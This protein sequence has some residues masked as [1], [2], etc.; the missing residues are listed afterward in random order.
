[1]GCD[2]CADEDPAEF[3]HLLGATDINGAVGNGGATAGFSAQG[4][5]TVLRWPSPSYFQHV[6]FVTSNDVNARA[7]PHFGA[8]D[9]Q[10][11]FAGVAVDG[12]FA[13]ARDAGWTSTQRY[14]ADDSST[15]VTVQ[16][17]N[18][19]RVSVRYTDT[20]APGLDVLS[21]RIEVTPDPGFVPRALRLVYF[22][23]FSPTVEKADFFPTDQ[24]ARLG[25]RDYAL[26]WSARRAALVHFSLPG[27]PPDLVAPLSGSRTA[28][29]IDATLDGI[30]A[31]GMFILLGA[32]RMPDGFQC[33]WDAGA[34]SA[35]AP[36]DAY[37]DAAA[38]IGALSGAPAALTHADGALRW[39]LPPTGGAVELF[40]AIG[41]TLAQASAALDEARARG[42]DAL[43]AAER[44]ASSALIAGARLP[45]TDDADRLRLAKRA[46][47]SIAV[48]RDRASGAIVASISSQPPY[49]LDWPRDGSFIDYALDVAGLHDWVTQHRAFYTTVQRK[50]DGDDA[51]S[52]SDAFAGSFAMDFYADGRP[53]GPISLEID[54]VGLTLWGWYEHA[55]WL[56][57][58]ARRAY[59]DRVWPSL[60]LAADLLV[61][62]VDQ[63]TRL[64]CAENE[65][66]SFDATI[67]LHG[68]IPVWLGV[69]SAARA[70]NYLHRS[71][72]A[73]RWAHRADELAAAIE[74]A[75][76]DPTLGYVG[77]STTLGDVG[78]IGPVA[79]TLWPARFHSFADPRMARA[80][81]QIVEAYTPFFDQTNGGGSYFG[82][83]LVAL[84]LFDPPGSD[85][86]ARTR[87]W[88][89]RMVKDVPT[90]TGHYGESF[91]FSGGTYTN[92]VSIPH[93][94][95]ATL[96]YLAL[97]AAYS[98]ET[99]ARAELAPATAPAD[100][101]CRVGGRA[102]DES[103][104]AL[105]LVG[106]CL[107][108]IARR[109]RN[110]RWDRCR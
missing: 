43:R 62:C 64:Q 79:W 74:R 63:K 16:H 24:T 39:E 45:A 109:R 37:D 102:A 46:L 70:A 47:L 27:R 73:R 23:N 28:A 51:V 12:S 97:M 72:E 60:R 68:A 42:G 25:D 103:A 7:L 38:T 9:N 106:G 89:D 61:R 32:D 75:F 108:L 107:F 88:I 20:I 58:P 69:S 3:E 71:D 6:D 53:G 18:S 93:L 4:E 33:G 100:C 8:R 55:K 91:V 50:S 29:E 84:A 65:D 19:L 87:R 49:N 13:W 82:K 26:A 95:E 22:E 98:P 34:P 30:S 36:R 5:L 1:L 99:F 78:A 52:G 44:D 90:P 57:E 15:L 14:A 40:I 59:L 10:G 80:A 54:E 35:G 56:D 83:G 101:G 66:D 11:S 81:A 96:T 41:G 48:G 76:G 92:V 21:R 86:A 110:G 94:W 31:E 104:L 77:G 105:G 85:G 67:T 2:A 17:S